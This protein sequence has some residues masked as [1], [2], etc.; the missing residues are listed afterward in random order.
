MIPIGVVSSSGIRFGTVPSAVTSFG[1]NKSFNTLTYSLTAPFDGGSPI[2]GYYVKT[3]TFDEELQEEVLWDE[4]FTQSGT[5]GYN[6]NGSA[7]LY[8]Y[9]INANGNGPQ[10]I[11]YL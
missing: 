4:K 3:T 1:V 2:T 8:A 9:A 10:N 11:Y 7:Y 5:I 6:P